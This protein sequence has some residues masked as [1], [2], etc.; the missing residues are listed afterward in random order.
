MKGLTRIAPTPSGFLHEGNRVNF[1]LTAQTAQQH[2]LALALRIDDVDT[3]RYRPE[4]VDDIFAVLAAMGIRWTVGPRDREDFESNWTQRRRL[5]LYRATCD[6]LRDSDLSTYVCRCSRQAM[7]THEG[8]GCPGECWR[9]DWPLIAGESCLRARLGSDCRVA[10]GN[11]EVD[12]SRG[13]GDFVVWRRDDL[14]AYQLVSVVE[15]ENL[16]TT[17]IVRGEDLLASSAAQI[18]LA[19]ALGYTA[20]PNALFVHH[21][22]V[23]DSQGKKLS[24]SQSSKPLGSEEEP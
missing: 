24:K 9:R 18:V 20:V 11:V 21:E 17:H 5:D 22:L 7:A 3:S 1:A 6:D 23:L 2:D 19:R 4:Y 12:L 14:P 8:E 16:A 10:V 15:D 13:I